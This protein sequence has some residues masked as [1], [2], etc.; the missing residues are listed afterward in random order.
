MENTL[1]RP[2][3]NRSRKRLAAALVALAL[4]LAACG[5]RG[6]LYLPEKAP[7]AAPA[8]EQPTT[9]EE[10]EDETDGAREAGLR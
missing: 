8:Q 7:E 6:P 3:S 2:S 1:R 4:L 5:Q 9:A 10:D